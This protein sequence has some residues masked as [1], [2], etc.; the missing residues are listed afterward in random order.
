MQERLRRRGRQPDPR[1]NAKIAQSG[2]ATV[3]RLVSSLSSSATQCPRSGLVSSK[4]RSLSAHMIAAVRL[5]CECACC[6][7][8]HPRSGKIGRL[9]PQVHARQVGREQEQVA[10]DGPELSRGKAQRL[11]VGGRRLLHRRHLVRALARQLGDAGMND[12]G[13]VV[14]PVQE[15]PSRKG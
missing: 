2:M 9:L 4:R 14:H 6:R 8:D 15:F 12:F 13:G 1:A 5:T 10:E 3:I 11:I 7:R